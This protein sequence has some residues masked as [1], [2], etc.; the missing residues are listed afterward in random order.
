MITET[1]NLGPGVRARV[2]YKDTGPSKPP[3]EARQWPEDT[4]W[5][6]V[7]VILEL[8]REPDGVLLPILGEPRDVVRT[9][10]TAM[11][12]DGHGEWETA[13][14]EDREP[15][16]RFR[17]IIRRPRT[18]DALDFARKAIRDVFCHLRQRGLDREARLIE[19][20]QR[21]QAARQDAP[22][23]LLG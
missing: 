15:V 6:W 19:R 16:T 13:H 2:Q 18:I 9:L 11:E 12:G 21:T 5:P 10:S 14:N 8:P 17:A 23:E 20:E 7:E 4:D 3:A 22:E 1:F